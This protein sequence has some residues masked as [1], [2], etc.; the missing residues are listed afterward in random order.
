MTL[1]RDPASKATTSDRA[2]LLLAFVAYDEDTGTCMRYAVY[3]LQT[4]LSGT[5]ELVLARRTGFRNI[6]LQLGTAPDVS[7]TDSVTGIFLAGGSFL[8]DIDADAGEPGESCRWTPLRDERTRLLTRDLR[9]G[10]RRSPPAGGRHRG[11]DGLSRAGGNLR[12]SHGTHPVSTLSSRERE[13]RR[14]PERAQQ[15]LGGLVL[16]VGRFFQ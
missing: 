6:P 14:G 15:S 9:C 12:Q 2:L 1:V 8:F 3:Q 13:R 4:V 5:S 7:S 16:D 10:T 11:R